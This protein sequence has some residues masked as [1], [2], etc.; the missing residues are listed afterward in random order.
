[1]IYITVKRWYWSQLIY[2]LNSIH[3]HCKEVQYTTVKPKRFCNI[4]KL[5][6]IMQESHAPMYI[7]LSVC[8]STLHFLT[9][10]PVYFSIHYIQE[11]KNKNQTFKHNPQNLL[12][13]GCISFIDKCCFPQKSH[14]VARN[15][16]TLCCITLSCPLCFLSICLLT[17]MSLSFFFYFCLF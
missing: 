3:M 12:L 17:I 14:A 8:T 11:N 4:I 15:L 5:T 9:R 16:V 6:W 7:Q 1:M 13:A 2:T 10:L